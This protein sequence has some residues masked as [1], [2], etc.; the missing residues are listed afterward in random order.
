MNIDT[1]ATIVLTTYKVTKPKIHIGT[2]HKFV[3][4]LIETDYILFQSSECNINAPNKRTHVDHKLCF[5]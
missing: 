3:T 4:K 1:P 5:L 2:V